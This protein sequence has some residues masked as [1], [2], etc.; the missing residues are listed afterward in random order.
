MQQTSPSSMVE[1]AEKQHDLIY[2]IKIPSD[3]ESVMG[4]YLTTKTDD[5]FI[6]EYV[7][8]TKQQFFHCAYFRFTNSRIKQ[9][10]RAGGLTARIVYQRCIE[11]IL[12]SR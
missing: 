5:F 8:L 4:N 9:A 2:E 12:L 6:D 7:R 11:A 3:S 1:A 10:E